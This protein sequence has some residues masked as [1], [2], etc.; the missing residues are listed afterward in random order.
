MITARSSNGF[1][2]SLFFHFTF[3]E[4]NV[5]VEALWP[6][7]QSGLLQSVLSVKNVYNK[8]LICPTFS[9]TPRPNSDLVFCSN[10][11]VPTD[12][13]ATTAR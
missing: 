9:R 6:R 13:F 12:C 1:K 4:N 8:R 3:F 2:K 5:T 11:A 7:F 10:L